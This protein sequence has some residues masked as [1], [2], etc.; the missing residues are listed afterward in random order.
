V[1]PGDRPLLVLDSV[2]GPHAG[3]TALDA[4]R[5]IAAGQPI[6]DVAL[7]YRY[8]RPGSELARYRYRLVD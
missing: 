5:S 1:P 7:P 8:A 6:M 4:A 3:T 2:A